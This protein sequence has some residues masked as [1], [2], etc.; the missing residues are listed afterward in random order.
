MRRV[1]KSQKQ[2]D[3]I[4][5]EQQE[6]LTTDGADKVKTGRSSLCLNHLLD[7]TT[8]CVCADVPDAMLVKAQAAS[9]CN[10]GLMKKERKTEVGMFF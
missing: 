4:Y 1:Q 5:R 9:N 2:W 10:E 6:T 8:A 7:L 3:S